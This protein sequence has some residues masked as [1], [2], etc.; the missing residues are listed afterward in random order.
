M[1]IT[2]LLLVALLSACTNSIDLDA[3]APPRDNSYV[4]SCSAEIPLNCI[5]CDPLNTGND[6]FCHLL[7]QNFNVCFGRNFAYPVSAV[8]METDCTTRVYQNALQLMRTIFQ[9]CDDIDP[10][11]SACDV[12]VSCTAISNN[13]VASS[14]D[15][16]CTHE[17]PA[18]SYVYERG[19]ITSN[20]FEAS[21]VDANQQIECPNETRRSTDL[22][23]V[24][25]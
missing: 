1:R 19:N 15:N 24:H 7:T 2:L 16:R 22:V 11:L 25:F 20:I 13:H 14:W 18:V 21:Y 9:V 10:H 23:C 3:S 12:R 6:N 17:C 8:E 4:C 5:Y